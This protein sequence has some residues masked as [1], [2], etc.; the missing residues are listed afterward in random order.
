MNNTANIVTPNIITVDGPSG[1]GKGTLSL[2]LADK[3]GWH[4]LDS[5]VL[6]RVLGVAA[7]KHHI[8]L[9][10]E[11]KVAQ[12]ARHLDID[13]KLNPSSQEVEPV[14]EGDNLAGLI[15]TDDAGQAASKVAVIPAAREA[16]LERQREF[17][18]LPGLV[19]DGR[20]MGT[21]VFPDAPVKIFLTASAERRAERR[22]KQ[23]KNKGVDA[24]MRAL[25]DSIKARDERDRTRPVAPLVPANGAFIIDSSELTITEV[26]T[27][28]LEFSAKS[29]PE[30]L[31]G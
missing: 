15:R 9:D 26:L 27:Q 18:R 20:D 14:L 12:L 2:L 17:Y 8:A 1:A 3:L 21:V 24:N 5:G 13:F 25:L 4:I 29:M 30:I 10:D 22:Y 16:L 6:Y 31:A 19:A 7:L 28:V 11:L 23:L